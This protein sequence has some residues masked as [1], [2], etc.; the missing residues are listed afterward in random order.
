M[1]YV[2]YAF[3][4]VGV[5]LSVWNLRDALIDFQF[6]S[7]LTS[8]GP[9]VARSEVQLVALGWVVREVG[10]LAIFLTLLAFLIHHGIGDV[11]GLCVASIVCMQ[12]GFYR[13]IR[14]QL[15]RE[16]HGRVTQQ[17]ARHDV[18]LA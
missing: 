14:W 15:L 13:L 6:T 9:V 1:T 3:L 2:E 7:S 17:A 11:S 8:V 12:S 5:A 10:N 16:W 4:F 18:P